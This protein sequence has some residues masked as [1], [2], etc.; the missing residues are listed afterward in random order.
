MKAITH[1]KAT[2]QTA[3][4]WEKN[5]PDCTGASWDWWRWL[6]KDFLSR[7]SGDST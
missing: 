7:R 4:G 3:R 5:D 1:A 6:D 2:A